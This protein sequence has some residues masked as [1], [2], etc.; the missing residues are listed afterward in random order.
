MERGFPIPV[1]SLSLGGL[2]QDYLAEC[3]RDGWISA[4]GPWVERFER[5]LASR[6]GRRFAI[7]VGSGSAALEVAVA[8]LGLGAG[9][10]VV[11][12]AHTIIACAQA[13]IRAGATPLLA[14]SDPLSWGIDPADLE[15]RLT[16]R[17]RAALVPHLYGLPTDMADV[18]AR[19][20]AA[21][22]AVIEDASQMIGAQCLG[23]PCGSFGAVST[24]SFFANKNL[25]TGEGGMVFTDDPAL[26]ERA[27]AYR[28]QGAQPARR[29]V[30]ESAGWNCR[31]SGLQAAFG[32]AQLEGLGERV[33]RKRALGLAYR[34]ALADVAALELPPADL[35]QGV[36]SYW[37]CGMLLRGADAGGVD[38]L[39]AA[40]AAD[41][42]EARPFFWPLHWQ[43]VY[44]REG[45]FAGESHPVAEDL[46]QRGFYLPS[47]ADLSHDEMIAVCERLRAAVNRLRL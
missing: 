29:F 6:V 40:L 12:P 3:V 24:A 19:A 43:P 33:G 34:E 14:D 20:E 17:T 37:A 36:N 47:G 41:G 18:L 25:T 15:R 45:R 44:R 42:V 39:L 10:E 28:D 7:A 22:I 2:E 1:N 21:G 11:L 9:D 5:A 35:P 4:R 16:G 32:L 13:V 46:A 8:A 31:M 30:H 23:R 26:A 27:R 38:R